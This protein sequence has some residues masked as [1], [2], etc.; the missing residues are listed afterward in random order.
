MDCSAYHGVPVLVTG[1]CGFIGSHITMALVAAGARVG[2]LDNLSHGQ[3][4]NLAPVADKVHIQVGDLRQPE[5]CAHAVAGKQIVF[6]LAALGSV[7]GSLDDPLRYHEVNATG[8]LNLL[9]AA[10]T[11]G[12]RRVVYSASSSAY[13]DSPSLPKREDMPPA[14][15]S[16]YAITK[17]MGEY[18]LRTFAEVY[19]LSTV[20]L[21]YFNVFGPRQNP[22]S[23]YAAVIPAFIDALRQGR[24]PTIHGDGEQTRDFCHVDNVVQANLL[25]GLSPK[26]LAGEVYNVACGERLSLN[27]LFRIIQTSVG[28]TVQPIYGPARMGDVRD[29]LADITKIVTDL[30]YHPQV[31]V[32]PGL[33]STVQWYRQQFAS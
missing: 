30:G 8:T 32:R 22:K 29:S 12:V 17:L 6:H 23:Q 15:K 24:A 21:R 33:A 11:A 14:P 1:G 28:A 2:V 3:R 9:L 25:A 26:A 27:E 18:Y 13:G 4:S 20:S 31:L 19:G 5:D 10:R 16:P 7:P